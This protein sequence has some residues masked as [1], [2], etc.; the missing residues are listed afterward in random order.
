MIRAKEALTCLL[1]SLLVRS[2]S[3]LKYRGSGGFAK[4]EDMVKV[5]LQ[6]CE[7][8]LRWVTM[9]VSKDLTRLL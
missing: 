2:E 4:D 1:G 3:F 7:Q 6:S 8:L 5:A 9:V